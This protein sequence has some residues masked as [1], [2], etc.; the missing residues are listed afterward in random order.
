MAEVFPIADKLTGRYNT[1]F[2]VADNPDNYCQPFGRIYCMFVF[3][4]PLR[5]LQ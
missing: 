3:S 5:I 2:D 4:T 1:R